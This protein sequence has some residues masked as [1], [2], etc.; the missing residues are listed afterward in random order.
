[1]GGQDFLFGFA[2][3][4]CFPEFRLPLLVISIPN[5]FVAFG[6]QAVMPVCA[7]LA[8]MIAALAN[9]SSEGMLVGPTCSAGLAHESCLL[10]LTFSFDS[11]DMAVGLIFQVLKHSQVVQGTSEAR[12]AGHGVILGVKTSD[13][14][15]AATIIFNQGKK[16]LDQGWTLS[17]FFGARFQMVKGALAALVE[18]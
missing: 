17:T 12:D 4:P 5:A 1:M 7:T 2:K 10:S 15:S 14:V 6:S 9:V 16:I 13:T 18:T 3:S 11:N 8:L